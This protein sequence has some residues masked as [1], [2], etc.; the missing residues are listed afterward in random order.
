MT[1]NC[2]RW[3]HGSSYE[4]SIYCEIHEALSCPSWAAWK[5]QEH[6]KDRESE[7]CL[8]WLEVAWESQRKN[9]S[10]N[11][12]DTMNCTWSRSKT[13]WIVH[14]ADY[15]CKVGRRHKNVMINA[16]CCDNRNDP[17]QHHCTMRGGSSETVNKIHQYPSM[18]VAS[19][20]WRSAEACG[21]KRSKYS[22]MI[23][24]KP[25][26]C[27]CANCLDMSNAEVSKSTPIRSIIQNGTDFF[28]CQ[29]STK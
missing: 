3:S 16:N 21:C 2:L 23:E 12:K 29:S 20:W 13:Q 5:A 7:A 15:E 14:G 11:F 28:D 24:E 27:W 8:A 10:Y 25:K 1:Q 22:T 9:R 6:V 17:S 18:R 19:K 26:T 4:R